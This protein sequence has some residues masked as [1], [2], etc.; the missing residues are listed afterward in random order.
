MHTEDMRA[1]GAVDL[2][3]AIEQARK[4]MFHLRFQ[5]AL[6]QLADTSRVRAARRELARLITVRREQEI[7]SAWEA[8]NEGRG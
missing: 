4:Q 1:L 7:Q 2:E 5:R 6:G 8:A 3:E